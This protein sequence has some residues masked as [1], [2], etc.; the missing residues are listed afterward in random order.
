MMHEN[1]AL[2][3]FPLFEKKGI[4]TGELVIKRLKL[5]ISIRTNKHENK[6]YNRNINN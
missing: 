1:H 3:S 5:Q 6:L 4:G 2:I